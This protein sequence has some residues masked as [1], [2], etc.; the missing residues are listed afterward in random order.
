MIKKQ[1]KGSLG[2]FRKNHKKRQPNQILHTWWWW[3]TIHQP[4]SI[5]WRKIL[6]ENTLVAFRIPV[7]M[8]DRLKHHCDEHDLCRSL[9]QYFRSTDDPKALPEPTRNDGWAAHRWWYGR[10]AAIASTS[11]SARHRWRRFHISP[12]WPQQIYSTF[13]LNLR[14]ERVTLLSL[15]S[16]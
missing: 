14:S 2:G 16:S 3:K 12:M 15:L 4:R 8:L 13:K 7:P 10:P 11:S 9:A 6:I 5:F 1:H